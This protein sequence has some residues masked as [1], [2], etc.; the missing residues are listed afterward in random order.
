MKA[1]CF[2]HLLMLMAASCLGQAFT[3]EDISF[4]S[5]SASTAVSYLLQENCEGTGT[6]SGWTDSAGSPNWD[7]TTNVIAGS[8][9]LALAFGDRSDS[10]TW[11]NTSPA[12]FFFALKLGPVP[13]NNTTIYSIRNNPATTNPVQFEYRTTG[14]IRMLSND[15]SQAATLTNVAPVATILYVWGDYTKGS[16]AN[17]V[18]HGYITT[19]QTKPP[20]PQATISNS[21]STVDTGVLRVTGPEGTFA[22]M[23]TF[24]VSASDIGSNPP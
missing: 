21:G 16:G 11:A 22:I 13:A 2:I 10:P 15:G 8:Q 24:R 19:T 12:Y 1:F 4:V 18:V 7:N 14:E 17:G 20:T 5:Q 9:S 23:D 3:L 6:P